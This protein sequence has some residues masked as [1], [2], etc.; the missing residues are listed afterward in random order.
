MTTLYCPVCGQPMTTYQQEMLNPDRTK[1]YI[2]TG[3]CRNPDDTQFYY[4]T[5]SE[6]TLRDGSFLSQWNRGIEETNKR[7]GENKPLIVARFDL[8]T[9]SALCG[10]VAA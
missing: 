4:N 5:A 10:E 1:Y 3:E 9:G 7:K 8:D 6:R 2:V